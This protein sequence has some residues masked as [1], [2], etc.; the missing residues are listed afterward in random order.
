MLTAADTQSE[1]RNFAAGG[2]SEEV[3]DHEDGY[4]HAGGNDDSEDTDK[5]ESLSPDDKP[6]GL[7]YARV[8][9]GNQL[10]GE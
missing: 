9:S 10:K 1:L 8:S 2:N 5:V 7:I 3:G 6:H 4:R